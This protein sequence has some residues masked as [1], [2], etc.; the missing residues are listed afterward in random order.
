[1]TKVANTASVTA[2]CTD[3]AGNSSSATFT[4]QFDKTPPTVSGAP[5]RPPDYNG[6][7]N[8]PVDVV[9]TGE[10]APSGV[11]SCTRVTC[12]GPDGSAV[13][14]A[15]T[16]TDNAGNIGAPVTSTPFAC[17]ATPPQLS[18][19]ITPGPVILH[20]TAVADPGATDNLAGI[21]SAS[22]APV[23]TSSVG[24]HTVTCRA[25]DKAGN[26]A[27]VLYGYTVGY[28]FDGFL[29]PINDTAHTLVCGSPCVASIFKGGCTVP[30]EFQL[31]HAAGNVIQ[32]SSAPVWLTPQQGGPTT[33][34][35][36]ES[37]YTD[38]ASGGT[39]YTWDGQ[40]YHYNWSTKGYAVGYFW[41]IGGQ[42]DD[43]QVYYV[44]IGLR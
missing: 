25:T 34:P 12:G 3:K 23:D 9:F 21:E 27:S 40:Q 14:P 5:N 10:D 35:V 39:T 17:D 42:F 41:R 15:G 1:M 29:Q 8:H 18:P 7:Y 2:I 16:R 22:C 6:W 33:S 32:S 43:G 13:A 44:Y 11:A 37:V 24:P 28:R 19:S 38:P 20:G 26:T 30:V 36:D 31:K 4:L